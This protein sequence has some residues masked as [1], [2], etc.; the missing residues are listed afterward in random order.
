MDLVRIGFYVQS[1]VQEEGEHVEFIDSPVVLCN[2]GVGSTSKVEKEFRWPLKDL[3]DYVEIMQRHNPRQS[4]VRGDTGAHQVAEGDG[5]RSEGVECR[6]DRSD[7]SNMAKVQPFAGLE[8]HT[9]VGLDQSGEACRLPMAVPDDGLDFPSEADVVTAA[10]GLS[11]C[12]TL[13]FNAD[14]HVADDEEPIA[15]RLVGNEIDVF[16]VS[17]ER[18]RGHTASRCHVLEVGRRRVHA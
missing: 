2:S 4:S 11:D 5:E 7:L 13:H 18:V 3:R 1:A 8:P 9:L 16:A 10:R 6:E 17:T 12:S 14:R 15:L